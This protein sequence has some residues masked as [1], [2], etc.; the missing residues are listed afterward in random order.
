M[1][2]THGKPGR[3][4]GLQA[5]GLDQRNGERRS[6]DASRPG[7]DVGAWIEKGQVYCAVV[8][9][10][11]QSAA[12]MSI[13]V[14]RRSQRKKQAAWLSGKPESAETSQALSVTIRI[15]FSRNRTA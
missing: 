2:A 1:A 14:D 13:R 9:A 12:V 15:L 8:R 5:A 10:G 11:V 4:G 3:A 6:A 7:A